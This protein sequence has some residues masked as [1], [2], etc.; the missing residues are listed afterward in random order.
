MISVQFLSIYFG[1]IPEV[2]ISLEL[3]ISLN[4]VLSYI[5]SFSGFCATKRIIELIE[6]SSCHTVLNQEK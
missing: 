6:S 2:L 5:Q 3:V 4:S 1:W